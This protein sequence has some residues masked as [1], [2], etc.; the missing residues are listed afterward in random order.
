M[1]ARERAEAD[2]AA[3]R[4]IDFEAALRERR[5]EH[6]AQIREKRVAPVIYFRDSRAGWRERRAA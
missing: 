6:V 1:H 3:T 2:S 5:R 4:I